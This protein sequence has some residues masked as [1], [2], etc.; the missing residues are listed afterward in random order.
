MRAVFAAAVL[1]LSSLGVSAETFV[2]AEPA[3]PLATGAIVSVVAR[4]MFTSVEVL[5]A[6]TFL[7]DPA[8]TA[9]LIARDDGI[10]APAWFLDEFEFAFAPLSASGSVPGLG[11]PVDL[12]VDRIGYR[13][14]HPMGDLSGPTPE[15]DAAV[16]LGRRFDV[17][18]VDV[19]LTGTMTVDGVPTQFNGTRTIR[20]FPECFN[21]NRNLRWWAVTSPPLAVD[22]ATRGQMQSDVFNL[23]VVSQDGLTYAIEYE[24]RL[25]D[26]PF[27]V[28]EPAASAAAIGVLAALGF[29]S[30]RRRKWDFASEATRDRA[31]KSP[32]G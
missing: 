21:T 8:A 27:L 32:T 16:P 18:F 15:N 4:D 2:L 14:F 3:V 7:D 13:A 22:L 25:E 1:T 26:V 17:R 10:L 5:Q 11:I 6:G 19:V 31:A 9:S 20:C 29:S 28:P 24:F 23:D 30:R 12:V